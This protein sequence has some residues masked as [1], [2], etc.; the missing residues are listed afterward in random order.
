VTTSPGP[1]RTTVHVV[2]G[3]TPSRFLRPLLRARPFGEVFDEFDGRPLLGRYRDAVKARWRVNWWSTRILLS[4]AVRDRLD[5]DAAALAGD[6]LGSRTLPAPLS[7]FAAAAHRVAERMPGE[8][9]STELVDEYTNASVLELRRTAAELDDVVAMYRGF[10]ANVAH[11]VSRAGRAFA[12]AQVLD[13]G[14]GSGYLPYALVAAGASAA[15]GLDVTVSTELPSE[16]ARVATGLAGEGAK[17]ARLVA[18]DVHEMP[19]DDASFDVVCS[20]SAVEH[21]QDARRAI[22]EIFRVLRPGGVTFHGVDPWFGMQ[23]GHALCTLDFPWGHARL[24][25]AELAGYMRRFRP[26]EADDAIE[27]HARYFQRPP[28]TLE[29]SRAAWTEAGFRIVEWRPLPV[30]VREPHRALLDSAV[31]ADVRRRHPT[32]SRRDL[33]TVGYTVVAVRS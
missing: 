7:D 21:F 5:P 9:L 1:V 16:R 19:F 6:L 2:L 10:A 12:G 17:A 13:V 3:A 32:A 23:G 29:E 24:D 4:P 26:F 18:G 15:V 30:P 14:T 33:L 27:A 8:I 22:A 25:D 20:G 28:L 11:S 31:L